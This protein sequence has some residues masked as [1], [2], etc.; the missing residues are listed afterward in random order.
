MF[1]EIRAVVIDEHLASSLQNCHRSRRAAAGLST[2]V[3]AADNELV[4]QDQI[5]HFAKSVGLQ[6]GS[7]ILVISDISG[8]YSKSDSQLGISSHSFTSRQKLTEACHPRRCQGNPQ[9]SN[10]AN[11]VRC[12]LWL[13]VL[14]SERRCSIASTTSAVS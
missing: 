3:A 6:L 10:S 4:T 5:L 7:E 12:V 1:S 11:L 9:G 14:I 13:A 2:A 8:L